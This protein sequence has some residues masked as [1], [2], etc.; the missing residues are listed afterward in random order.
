[1]NI[2]GTIK[3]F[4]QSIIQGKLLLRLRINDHFPQILVCIVAG[5][6]A[7]VFSLMIEN[8]LIKVNRNN[9]ILERQKDEI[10]LKTIELSEIYS[11]S[12]LAK[13][14]EEMD[15]E[16]KEPVKPAKHLKNR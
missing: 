9:S 3:N 14:L 16:L 6:V 10:A 8:T 5:F 13:K 4:L 7:I 2:A 11:R 15:S 1:M 12:N